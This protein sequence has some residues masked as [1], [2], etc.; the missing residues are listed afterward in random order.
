MALCQN[1]GQA[2]DDNL[3][4]CTKCGHPC[5][6]AK[7]D[8]LSGADSSFGL[9]SVD[10]L[11]EA[12]SDQD[13]LNYSF[14]IDTNVGRQSGDKPRESR[15]AD[16][17]A[18]RLSGALNFDGI[19]SSS[20]LDVS[21]GSDLSALS[22]DSDGI[23]TAATLSLPDNSL[24]IK[25]A[26]STLEFPS[27]D[28][29]FGN[30]GTA[31]ANAS[32]KDAR[33]LATASAKDTR[34]IAA[35]AANK[36]ADGRTSAINGLTDD[37]RSAAAGVG[38][39][40]RG[41][42]RIREGAERGQSL[43]LR[44]A[45]SSIKEGA[46]DVISG[47]KQIATAAGR[48]KQGASN[49]RVS[50]LRY[51]DVP[52]AL[53]ALRECVELSDPT[54]KAMVRLHSQLAELTQADVPNSAAF[55][56]IRNKLG[57]AEQVL[58][59]LSDGTDAARS[60]ILSADR[61][62]GAGG[63]ASLQASS[64]IERADRIVALQKTYREQADELVEWWRKNKKSLYKAGA[65]VAL[66]AAVSAGMQ[67]V[68]GN[69]E[70]GIL[71]VRSDSAPRPS[72][73][74]DVSRCLQDCLDASAAGIKAVSQ[75]RVRLNFILKR[76]RPGKPMYTLLTDKLQETDQLIED[77]STYQTS[78]KR[79]NYLVNSSDARQIDGSALSDLLGKAEQ[80]KNLQNALKDR[81]DELGGW[82]KK[83]KSGICDVVG[84]DIL[85]ATSTKS[86]LSDKYLF[87]SGSLSDGSED[88]L[89]YDGSD[90]S[91]G[92]TTKVHV[93]LSVLN[94]LLCPI[95]LLGFVALG[96]TVVYFFAV[97]SDNYERAK[98]YSSR[99]WALNIFGLLCF[100]LGK[101]IRL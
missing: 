25:S 81:A 39:V 73:L 54:N 42:S 38:S 62:K 2:I 96:L 57:E 64:L 84:D 21:L 9:S 98:T 1:C 7:A 31:L 66:G 11:L 72:S 76:L 37:V 52:T 10:E 53:A 40:S 83:H 78:V 60:I 58:S 87:G 101:M 30:S 16:N 13:L 56:E 77:L 71:Q 88:D 47:S 67:A 28:L 45:V 85:D 36:G 91:T 86:L 12:N 15:A 29:D 26:A 4:F 92:G 14:G 94:L 82:W 68:K 5:Q 55:A 75:V 90:T 34:A 79:I 44:T 3:A 100:A 27:A 65:A 6:N 50:D 20:S 32:V 8:L 24:D 70:Q 93:V 41:I 35:A 49:I 18:D 19:C 33:A 61:S 99:I 89:G 46:S 80:V 69:G 97:Q 51:E 95:P 63:A 43:E 23:G 17:Y 59:H 74:P 22:S 48:I